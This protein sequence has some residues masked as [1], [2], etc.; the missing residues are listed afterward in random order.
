[1]I[2]ADAPNARTS[3]PLSSH[4]ANI[5]IRTNKT[6]KD[7]VLWATLAMSVDDMTNPQ[8][9]NHINDDMLLVW[10]EDKTRKRQQRNVL[11]RTRGL[12]E[13]D[14]L[15]CRIG[16]SPRVTYVPSPE[17]LKVVGVDDAIAIGL[18]GLE[19]Q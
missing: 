14:G 11:A 4:L 3:D 9:L 5:R 6:L 13:R 19:K 18:F 1:M 16:T 12:L 15:I 17:L 10:I 2:G 8:F 7:L